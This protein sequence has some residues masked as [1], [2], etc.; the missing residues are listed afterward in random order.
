MNRQLFTKS[1]EEPV[2]KRPM[3]CY[4]VPSPSVAALFFGP[5][6]R[7]AAVVPQ[8]V[9][10]TPTVANLTCLATKGLILSLVGYP[11]PSGLPFS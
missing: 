11:F 2:L 5:G 1:A 6:H 4:G 8:R 9:K 10:N 7:G 3:T